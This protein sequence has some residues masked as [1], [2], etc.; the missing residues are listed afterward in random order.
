MTLKLV[1]Y[2]SHEC[3]LCAR[4]AFHDSSV[5]SEFGLDF[6]ECYPESDPGSELSALFNQYVATDEL[7]GWPTYVLI[8][9]TPDELKPLGQF[10]GAAPKARFREIVRRLMGA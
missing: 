10:Q 3:G 2:S 6:E 8:I 9:Q 5:A 7:Y 4:M 1:K